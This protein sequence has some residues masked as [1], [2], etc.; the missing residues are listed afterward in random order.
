MPALVL[1]SIRK[2]YGDTLVLPG[3]SLRVE[4]GECVAVVGPSGC[5]KTTLLRVIAGLEAIDGGRVE[6]GGRD[7]T[8]AAPDRRDVAMV[9][10]GA[11]VY[12]H[13]DVRGNLSLPLRTRGAGRD[14]IDRRVVETAELLGIRALLA[15]R[16]HDLSGGE[17]QRVAIGRAIVRRP[18]LF[19]LDEPLG[20][21]DAQLRRRLRGELK[22]LV[23]RLGSPT[24]APSPDGAASSSRVP[25]A[26]LLV[27]HDHEEAMALGDRIVVLDGGVVLQD[28]SPETIYR[29]PA[30]R[31]VAEFI[32]TPGMNILSASLDDNGVLR[33]GRPSSGDD[34]E[35]RDLWTVR[36]DS[37]QA[38]C[39]R[40]AAAHGVRE[41][42]V[43]VRPEHLRR[44]DSAR[45]PNDHDHGSASAAM[46]RLDV[47]ADFV[48]FQGSWIDVHARGLDDVGRDAHRIVARLPAE[49][50]IAPGE[51]L[52]LA[53]SR[54]HLHF[55]SGAGE[56]IR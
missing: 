39:L 17:R 19:L 37:Q 44:V 47:R 8:T 31:F 36:L 11:P 50:P 23:R 21:L 13:M 43:G 38:S 3:L 18:G 33:V 46:L 16:P 7:V 55:F 12:P 4:P 27:T 10:Q 53:T 45:G 52:V 5:G 32:G 15:R 35:G 22:A 25:T 34:P 56:A 1:D 51:R 54:E 26:T 24:D 30:S 14:E 40:D 41:F 28:G 9:F 20:S 49:S 2:R 48:E 6:I 29:L 42:V